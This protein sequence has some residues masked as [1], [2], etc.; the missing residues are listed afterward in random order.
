[1]KLQL[2]GV[3]VYI[4]YE[5]KVIHRDD[6]EFP[7]GELI[8]LEVCFPRFKLLLCAVYRTQGATNPFW[9]HF[10]I[11]IEQA[12]NYTP[13]I[14][15]TGDL[16]VNLLSENKN[17]LKDIIEIYNIPNYINEAMRYDVNGNSSRPSSSIS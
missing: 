2:G 16:N 4:A 9:E 5:L 14:V 17:I 12:L 13:N 8:F 6:L 1:M 3:L 7:N 10:Q 15:I 11:S